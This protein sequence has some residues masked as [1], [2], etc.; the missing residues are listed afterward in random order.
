[1]LGD[2]A[3]NNYICTQFSAKTEMF[4]QKNTGKCSGGIA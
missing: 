3:R 4:T 2:V 1:M